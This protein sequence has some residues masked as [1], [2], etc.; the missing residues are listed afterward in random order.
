LSRIRTI[1]PDFWDDEKLSSIS[2]DAR[3][4]FIGLWTNSDDYG[5]VKGHP[6]WL[7]N[8]IFPYDQIPLSNFQEW[9]KELEF[10]GC[11]FPFCANTEKYY[12]IKNFT[13]HQIISRP[14]QRK[15]PSPP[16]GLMEDSLRTHGGLTEGSCPEGE[17][18]GERERE[19]EGSL[20]AEESATCPHQ[21]II[22]LYHTILPEL[23]QVKVWTPKRQEWLRARWKEDQAR[24]NLG[25]WKA[26]FLKIKSSAFL[27][28]NVTNFKVDLEWVVNQ[29][30]M[31]KILEGKYD[32]DGKA[33]RNQTPGSQQKAPGAAGRAQSDGTPWPADEQY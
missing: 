33:R 9:L 17:G 10:L 28:G 8:T 11:I 3:L 20:V 15:N 23:A 27:T 26:Y 2:R 31:V 4:T 29:S 24:Q 12:F 14:S 6:G 18:E 19:R 5:V 13:K 30:N 21:K 1:K 22:D 7:K 32:G 25:W 16:D